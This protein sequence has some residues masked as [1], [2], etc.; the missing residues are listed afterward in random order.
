MHGGTK[1]LLTID[2]GNSTAAYGLFE[3]SRLLANG[4]T[5]SNY[6]PF[7]MQLIA[8]SGVY[9]PVKKVI[10][11]SVVPE[12]TYKI[13][14]QLQNKLGRG[15]VYVVGKDLKLRVPM[16]YDRR[17]L[18]A[19]RLV[20]L[21]G[22]LHFYRSPLLV[23]DFGTAITFDYLSK[24]G[25]F[26]GG[27]IVPGVETSFRALVEQAALLPKVKEVA[28]V[29]G[30]VGRNTKAAMSSGLLNGFGA[31]ADGLSGRFRAFYGRN[32]KTLVTGGFAARIAPFM[33]HV[34]YLDPLHT[35]RSL[36]LIYRKEIEPKCR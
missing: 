18:G 10:M 15:S 27:L 25:V 12:L 4:H 21:Y 7:F 29:K 23:I 20:N 11:S 8:K 14:K 28:P 36:A 16:R 34:D 32:L 19:D 24:S 9:K 17:K 26:E 3:G 5:E 30:L 6:I 1:L 22:A 13:K 2:L 33:A 35:I 31:L